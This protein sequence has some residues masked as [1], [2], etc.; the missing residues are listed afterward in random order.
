MLQL[1][2]NSYYI[3]ISINHLSTAMNRYISIM[4]IMQSRILNHLSVP[5][6]LIVICV[7]VCGCD[8]MSERLSNVGR[9]PKL[10]QVNLYE[11]K[12]DP[13]NQQALAYMQNNP[14]Y[15][16]NSNV[17]QQ[18]SQ[19][20]QSSASIWPTNAKSFLSGHKIGDLVSIVVSIKDKATL[21]NN[22]NKARGSNS[23]LGMPNMFGLEGEVRNILP[24]S[25]STSPASLVSLNSNA[26]SFGTGNINRKEVVETVIGTTVI[27]V[28]P[29]GNLVV[30]GS[31]EVRVNHE[32]RE[33]TIEGIV[34]PADISPNN[35]V[36][37]DRV[38]EARLSY[39][40]RGAIAEYQQDQYGKQ[41]LDIISPF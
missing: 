20:Q 23:K 4:N 24:N 13:T 35:T 22:T 16:P 29:G 3:A 17:Y 28:L 27:R 41:I 34:R 37:L 32:V 5:L 11:T 39:G 1:R 9:A 14:M 33:I 18:N 25:G 19:P 40:G 6:K 36:H 8:I 31:Q 15:D 12:V 10:S 38:S 21:N 30:R 26:N 7:M 2:V